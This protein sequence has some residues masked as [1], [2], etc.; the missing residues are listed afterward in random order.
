MHRATGELLLDVAV[1][2]ADPH[3]RHVRATGAGGDGRAR[4][5]RAGPGGGCTGDR[6][7]PLP[8][9]GLPARPAR[10]DRRSSG[11]AYHQDLP[12]REQQ[13]IVPRRARHLPGLRDDR[14]L[15]RDGRAGLL[16]G[17]QVCGRAPS[18]GRPTSPGAWAPAGRGGFRRGLR[19]CRTRRPTRRRARHRGLDVELAPA[20]GGRGGRYADWMEAPYNGILSGISLDGRTYFY[21]NPWPTEAATGASPGS[22]QPAARRTSPARCSPCRGTC[23]ARPPKGCGC[24]TSA[25]ER[26]RW[27][28]RVARAGDAGVQTRYP[29]D[30][31]VRVGCGAL[32]ARRTV[33][34]VPAP[35]RLV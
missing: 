27:P 3:L 34:A 5:D 2:L 15:R 19:G 13:E 8:P 12:V 17:V 18:A 9:G 31:E 26:W 10:G 6:R 23:T 11:T 1:R 28:S 21:Q 29:W 16:E 24:T 7:C 35:A 14:R 25:P 4:G 33:D 32:P 20:G 22:A 30:G